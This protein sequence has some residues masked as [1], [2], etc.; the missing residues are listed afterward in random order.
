MA[1]AFDTQISDAGRD[2][3]LTLYS[4][5]E[6]TDVVDLEPAFEAIHRGN[7]ERYNRSRGPGDFRAALQELDGAFLSYRSGY[8][9]FIN[10]SIRDYAAG[11]ICRTP[12][13]AFDVASSAVRFKQ[14]TSLWSLA[15]E[16]SDQPLFAALSADDSRLR[17]LFQRVLH[18]ESTRLEKTP[19][20][21][22]GRPVDVGEEDRL[23]KL[24]EICDSLRSGTFVQLCEQYA[25]YLVARWE[26][27]WF[28]ISSAL[29]AL[30]TMD[31]KDWYLS[32]GGRAVYRAILDALLTRLALA[33]ANDWLTLLKFPNSALE[34]L[35][36][37]G[38]KLSEALDHYRREGVREDFDNCS[39]LHDLN[40]LRTS[41]S[42]LTQQHG[43]DFAHIL[44]S[45]DEAIAE[46][47]EREPEYEG[48]ESSESPPGEPAEVVTEDEVREMFSTLRG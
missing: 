35:E 9:A 40:E 36:T 11:V 10:P 12:A 21:T 16:R 27:H 29:R 33:D 1:Y 14:I 13:I 47:D 3:I 43:L 20:G 45:I 15:T 25:T 39:D 32:N 6:W 34:W 4:L 31:G 38:A 48:G 28:H 17:S 8:A 22:I 23:A 44:S 30:D 19:R 7:S 42:E 5:G 26:N 46:G 37:D 2:L 41:L 18:G 24:V